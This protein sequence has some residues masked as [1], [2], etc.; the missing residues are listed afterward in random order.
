MSFET[1]TKTTDGCHRYYSPLWCCVGNVHTGE[2]PILRC[3]LPRI[4]STMLS[5]ADP[6]PK[7]FHIPTLWTSDLTQWSFFYIVHIVWTNDSTSVGEV[8]VR[9]AWRLKVLSGNLR[10]LSCLT[11]T[12]YRHEP[13]SVRIHL[14]RLDGGL[15][16]FEGRKIFYGEYRSVLRSVDFDQ[17]RS[18]VRFSRGRSRKSS[19]GDFQCC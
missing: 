14:Y 19:S 15:H 9:L 4:R 2:N 17:I 1:N 10:H 18:F 6:A 11:A 7:Q 13:I 12:E 5:G 8:S 16:N 3:T